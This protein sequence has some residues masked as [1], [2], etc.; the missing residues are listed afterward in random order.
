MKWKIITLGRAALA[1]LAKWSAEGSRYSKVQKSAAAV[2]YFAR[3]PEED[4]LLI[5]Q[6]Y[7]QHDE[8]ERQ[9]LDVPRH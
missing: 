5:L 4:R 1:L 6:E 3:L 9:R 2:C 8:R 7:Q